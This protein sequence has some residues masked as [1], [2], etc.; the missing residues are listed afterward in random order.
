MSS[1]T[2]TTPWACVFAGVLAVSVA[3]SPYV[4]RPADSPIASTTMANRGRTQRRGHGR[5]PQAEDRIRR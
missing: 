1:E 4:A 2:A 3:L 5:D